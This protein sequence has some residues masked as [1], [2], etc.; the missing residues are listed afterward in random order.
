MRSSFGV[1]TANLIPWK[2]GCQVAQEELA[3]AIADRDQITAEL[4]RVWEDH[5]AVLAAR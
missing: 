2:L 3:A 4:A 1:A 5:E